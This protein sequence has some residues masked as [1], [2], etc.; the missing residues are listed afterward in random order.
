MLER[1]KSLGPQAFRLV[2]YKSRVPS[3]LGYLSAEAPRNLRKREL[4]DRAK[5]SF[6]LFS[7]FLIYNSVI[8][9]GN[10]SPNIP[11]FCSIMS[12]L[13]I[14][15]YPLSSSLY[16]RVVVIRAPLQGLCYTVR[17][18]VDWLVSPTTRWFRKGSN[19]SPLQFC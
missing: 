14:L 1:G 12:R 13:C 8:V 18:A 17:D 10:S 3:I 16:Y 19:H 2:R 7:D 4:E 9:L 11:I 15:V 6:L 5:P